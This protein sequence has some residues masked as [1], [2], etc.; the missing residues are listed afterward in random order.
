VFKRDGQWV[1]EESEFLANDLTS[2][3]GVFVDAD[4]KLTIY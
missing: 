4:R 2:T 3:K 1:I